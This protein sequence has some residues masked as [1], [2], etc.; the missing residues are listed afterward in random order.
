MKYQVGDLFKVIQ[1]HCEGGIFRVTELPKAQSYNYRL[2]RLEC[3]GREYFL[4]EGEEDAWT[5]AY[6][7][8]EP[9]PDPLTLDLIA[10]YRAETA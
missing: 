7:L 10:D 5:T 8:P 9:E 1:G 6:Y 2:Q 4:K 3:D